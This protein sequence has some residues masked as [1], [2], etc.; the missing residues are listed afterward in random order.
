MYKI[1]LG[2][3][4]MTTD[5]FSSCCNV[6][7]L[8][9]FSFELTKVKSVFQAKNSTE[10]YPERQITLI[11]FLKYVVKW[12]WTTSSRTSSS[13]HLCTRLHCR[14]LV[15][16]QVKFV[17]KIG[18]VFVQTYSVYYSK[19]VVQLT[20]SIQCPDLFDKLRLWSIMFISYEI[21]VCHCQLNI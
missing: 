14:T 11:S 13:K 3:V 1:M 17:L 2:Q 12:S 4:F 10:V 6:H 21:Y 5:E 18:T 16:I 19:P 20:I 9:F 15:F 8:V 7:E